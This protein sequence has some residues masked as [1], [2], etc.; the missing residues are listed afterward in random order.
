MNEE[1]PSR[2]HEF[3]GAWT[4]KK[5]EAVE[6]YLI[7][8]LTALK[9]QS[10]QKYYI[11]CFAGSGYR[12]EGLVD[13]DG[14]AA[15]TDSVLS[16][17]DGSARKALR[18][19]PGFDRMILVEKDEARF[20]SLEAMVGQFGKKDLVELHHAD[21]TELVPRI[22]ADFKGMKRGVI[23]VD[24][25]GM[26]AEWSMMEA[27]AGTGRLDSWILVPTGVAINRLLPQNQQVTPGNE[28]KLTRFFG[29]PREEWYDAIYARTGQMSLFGGEERGKI[30]F[31]GLVK[32][33]TKRLTTIFPSVAS[34]PGPLKN[35]IGVP[36]FHL[37]FASGAVPER[38]GATA[39]KIATHLLKGLNA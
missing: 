21:A 16:Y 22:C 35:Q 29:C 2:E 34:I 13:F 20:R 28:A 12:N 1:N 4:E 38:G 7:S 32:F 10:F 5:L 3:G 26:A 31:E 17:R 37:F 33:Y 27:I 15:T 25:Y 11:D 14:R 9:K 6:H 23:F 19:N 8:Y 39:V 24:P 36:I 18:L 30:R